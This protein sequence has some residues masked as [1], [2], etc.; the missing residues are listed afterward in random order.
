VETS[1]SHAREIISNNLPNVNDKI[2]K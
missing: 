2:I 1:V